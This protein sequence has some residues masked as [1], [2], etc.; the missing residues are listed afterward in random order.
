MKRKSFMHTY[1]YRVQI[2]WYLLLEVHLIKVQYA[3][4]RILCAQNSIVFYSEN[5]VIY[6]IHWSKHHAVL[7]YFIY[8]TNTDSMFVLWVIWSKL[9]W[10][11]HIFFLHF[12]IWHGVAHLDA[13]WFSK[14]QVIHFHKNNG[15]ELTHLSWVQVIVQSCLHPFK[16]FMC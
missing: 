13:N 15:R 7:Q 14:K 3:V 1:M 8:N 12:K 4:Q 2:T 5:H 16:S 11:R 9:N 10:S 6:S